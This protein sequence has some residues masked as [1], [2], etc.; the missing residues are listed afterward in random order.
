MNVNNGRKLLAATAL[1]GLGLAL[2]ACAGNPGG[3]LWGVD[4]AKGVQLPP[5]DFPGPNNNPPPMPPK[6]TS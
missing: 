1:L 3:E 5:S 6:T 4:Y 2:T